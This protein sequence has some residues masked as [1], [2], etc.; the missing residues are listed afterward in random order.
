MSDLIREAAERAIAELKQSATGSAVKWP[1]MQSVI[2]A[3]LR[4]KFTGAGLGIKQF[5]EHCGG[6][7]WYIVP[8]YMTDD[9]AQEQCRW[10]VETAPAIEALIEA[11]VA[12]A[13]REALEAAIDIIATNT[14]WP[15]NESQNEQRV[16]G[17]EVGKRQ[18]LLAARALASS[19]PGSEVS[20]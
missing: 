17:F 2:E 6:K 8:D 1:A 7:G 9:L 3:A 16:I 20:K 13:R 10:C 12:A 11:R 4:E 18:A 5:C 15:I 19:E 14:L